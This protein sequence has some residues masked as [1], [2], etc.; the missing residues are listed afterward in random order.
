M[1]KDDD[2]GGQR[3]EAVEVARLILP[4]SRETAEVEEPGEEALDLPAALVAA[5]LPA[6]LPTAGVRGSVGSDQLDVIVG[7][8]LVRQRRRVVRFVPDELVRAEPAGDRSE[9]FG[10]ELAL[11]GRSAV[12]GSG[13]RNAVPSTIAMILV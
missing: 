7:P 11:G 3:E 6:V 5:E 12:G 13:Q 10:G 4:A 1:P 8:Q 9:S 2:D